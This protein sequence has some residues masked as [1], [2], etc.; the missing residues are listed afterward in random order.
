MSSAL[1]IDGMFWDAESFNGDVSN[2]NVMSCYGMNFLFKGATSF[3]G[4]LSN[5]LRTS[6][7]RYI[8]EMFAGATS[9]EG[10]GV[11]NWDVSTVGSLDG[12]FMDAIAFNADLSRWNVSTSFTERDSRIGT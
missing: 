7:N 8:Q 2:W 5:W 11:G 3:N 12:V 10:L 6:N 1:Y 9:F 4:D